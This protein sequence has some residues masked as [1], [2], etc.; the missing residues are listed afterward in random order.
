M[1]LGASWRQLIVG[2]NRSCENSPHF[3]AQ[4][5]SPKVQANKYTRI[6]QLCKHSSSC[7]LFFC[8]C[9][10]LCFRLQSCLLTAYSMQVSQHFQIC[11]SY[12][13]PHTTS[14][15]EDGPRKAGYTHL[16]S[17]GL[18]PH[19][20]SRRWKSWLGFFP[21]ECPCEIVF[22]LYI[23]NLTRNVNRLCR[24]GPLW[25]RSVVDTTFQR[26]TRECGCTH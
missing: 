23:Q 1:V 17:R 10:V 18:R 7:L 3:C 9:C 4:Y 8:F 14:A 5:I 11:I 16:H 20:A 21:F 15:K 24:H 22:N 12:A 2:E 6:V 13:I 26:T 19:S 25:K